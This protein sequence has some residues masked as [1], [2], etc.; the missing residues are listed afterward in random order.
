MD[1]IYHLFYQKYCLCLLFVCIRE[2]IATLHNSFLEMLGNSNE[3][4]LPLCSNIINESKPTKKK[5]LKSKFNL[6]FEVGGNFM[7]LKNAK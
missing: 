5:P 7:D 6:K 1:L 3:S 4:K 2:V